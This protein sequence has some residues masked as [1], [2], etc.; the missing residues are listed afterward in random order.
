MSEFKTFDSGL[1]DGGDWSL[2]AFFSLK[3]D[4]EVFEDVGE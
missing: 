1:I 2:K 4:V 3:R